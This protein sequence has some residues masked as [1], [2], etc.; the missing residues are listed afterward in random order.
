MTIISLPD[1]SIVEKI[2]PDR[3]A[4]VRHEVYETD[5]AIRG[6]SEAPTEGKKVSKEISRE[7]QKIAEYDP[8]MSAGAR[9]IIGGWGVW[10]E[11]LPVEQLTTPQEK[12]D[13]R[14][15]LRM[16][17]KLSE[18]YEPLQRQEMIEK[19]EK[20]F[21]ATSRRKFEKLRAQ[22]LQTDTRLQLKTR[23]GRKILTTVSERKMFSE[24]Q[25]ERF[26]SGMESIRK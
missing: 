16:R 10:R 7:R 1:A 20:R 22:K 3:T 2:N 19:M 24:A 26:A 11:T 21:D 15:F 12:K 9:P 18:T 13:Y 17:R 4:V 14:D 25:A 5:F 8:T 23:F 6:G